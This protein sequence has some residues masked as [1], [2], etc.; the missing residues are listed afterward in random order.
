MS[1]FLVACA[2][3]TGAC[4]PTVVALG[5]SIDQ[6]WPFD[7]LRQW[8][9]QA[10]D[11]TVPYRLE[12]EQLEGFEEIDDHKVYTIEFVYDCFNDSGVCEDADLDGT[13]DIEGTVAATWRMSSSGPDGVLFHAVDDVTYDPPVALADGR[14]AKNDEIVTESGG[15]TY[16]AVYN[17]KVTCPAPGLWPEEENRPDCFENAIDDGDADSKVGGTY[18]ATT[19]FSLVAFQQGDGVLWQL[20]NF[21]VAE[22]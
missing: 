9:F 2:L 21:D 8:T 11:T 4:T 14:M 6:A 18:W 20:R 22:R 1:R 16:T 15:V 13:E 17:G 19:R 7:E 3:L 5:D 10:E 12:A